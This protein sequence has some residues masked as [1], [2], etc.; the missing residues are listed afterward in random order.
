MTRTHPIARRTSWL[1]AVVLAASMLAACSGDDPGKRSG[2][3]AS[4]QSEGPAPIAATPPPPP[5]GSTRFAVVGDFGVADADEKAVAEMIR[6]ADERSPF[7]ALLTV[8]DNVYPVPGD[9]DPVRAAWTDPYGWV[10][11]RGLDVIATLGDEDIELDGTGERVMRAVGMPDRWYHRRVGPVDVLALDAT[12]ANA[13]EQSAWIRRTLAGANAPFT[14]ALVHFPP[15]LCSKGGFTPPTRAWVE[16]FADGGV[17]LVLSGNHHS[18]Q[19]FSAQDGVTYAIAG[20]GGASLY[21]VTPKRCTRGAP[22]LEA[23]DDQANGFLELGV[24]NDRLSGQAVAADGAVLDE[25]EIR[26]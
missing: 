24:D 6:A 26:S 10:E 17:D 22:R 23:Y 12:Q 21:D 1:P 19:R 25:F 8:G 16:L 15:Y 14:I 4:P 9:T 3:P 11:S 7:D 18:Y 13:D 5:A 2:T 20:N